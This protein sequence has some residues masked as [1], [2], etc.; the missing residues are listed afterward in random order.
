VISFAIAL[1]RAWTRFYTLGLPAEVRDARRGEIDSDLWEQQRHA[2]EGREGQLSTT[3]QVLLR[4][5]PGAPADIIW[6]AEAG[7][8]VRSG[9]DLNM[10]DKPWTLRRVISLALALLLLPIPAAWLNSAASSRGTREES[11]L[12]AVLLSIGANGSIL[13]IGLGV[14]TIFYEGLGASIGDV[15]LGS[16][17]IAAGIASFG[18]LYLARMNP[19]PGLA[20]IGG[21]T[22]AMVLLASWALAAVIIIGI[23]LAALA[24][25]RWLAPVPPSPV[26]A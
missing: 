16:A 10:K 21:A 11:T 1:T 4:L 12:S 13:P 7:A 15:A 9:R 6:R 23:A 24:I 14:L 3:L 17:E 19:V 2:D 26:L 22:A 20:L 18:G 8:A 5:I 25:A